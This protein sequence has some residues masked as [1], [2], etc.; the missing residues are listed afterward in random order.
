MK[1]QEITVTYDGIECEVHI[2]N[3]ECINISIAG[4][5]CGHHMTEEFTEIVEQMAIDQML[6]ED[7]RETRG[8][9]EYHF[10]KDEL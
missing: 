1:N 7:D 5:L 3:G 2:A 4:V 10:R 6:E 9:D 8:C